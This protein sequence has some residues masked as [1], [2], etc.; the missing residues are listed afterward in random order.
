MGNI[1]FKTII[2]NIKSFFGKEE[3]LFQD[4]KQIPDTA[5]EVFERPKEQRPAPKEAPKKI[6][7]KELPEAKPKLPFT[8]DELREAVKKPEPEPKQAD[9]DDTI[10]HEITAFETALNEVPE[11]PEPPV[12]EPTTREPT[13][14]DLPKGF[15]DEFSQY[16]MHEDLDSGGMLEGNVLEKMKQFHSHMKETNEYLV[17]TNEVKE[18]ISQKLSELQTLEREWF[19]STQQVEHLKKGITDIEKAIEEHSQ[20]LQALVKEAKTRTKLEKTAKPGQE[21]VLWDGRKL[22]S[23]LDLRVAL[24]TMPDDVF[25]H[26]VTGQQNDFAAWVSDVLGEKELGRQIRGITDKHRLQTILEG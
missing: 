21:F 4:P 5:S 18:K 12:Q 23:L 22:S 3:E 11:E 26:H 25:K 24:A 15:F 6:V 8:P 14:P 20:D 13:Q 19:H 9:L 1:V 16:A 2:E 17:Y 10:H 7:E